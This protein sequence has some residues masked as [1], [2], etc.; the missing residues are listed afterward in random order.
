MRKVI[1]IPFSLILVAFSTKKRPDKIGEDIIPQKIKIFSF[2]VLKKEKWC[3]I[4]N[5]YYFYRRFW[6]R[7]IA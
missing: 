5:K 1:A 4:I 3:G 7:L 6:D 2:F